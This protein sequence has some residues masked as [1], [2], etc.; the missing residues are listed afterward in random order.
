MKIRKGL[1][2]R[3][4]YLNRK[5]IRLTLIVYAVIIILGFLVSLSA[6]VGN[7]SKITDPD[8]LMIIKPLAF[9][10]FNILNPLLLTY[11]FERTESVAADIKS[12]WLTFAATTPASSAERSAAFCISELISFFAALLLSIVNLLLFGAIDGRGFDLFTFEIIL[13]MYFISAASYTMQC[14]QSYWKKSVNGGTLTGVIVLYSMIGAIAVVG[15]RYIKK[16][17]DKLGF[18]LGSEDAPANAAKLIMELMRSDA[19]KLLKVLGIIMPFA[20]I[21]LFVAVFFLMKKAF[22]RKG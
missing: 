22:E 17:P 6:K 9:Y 12:G 20:T 2:F 15:L 8:A 1:I 14:V 11:L 16:L 18:E 4:L 10:F 13:V 7:I 5:K 19:E 3:E 21:A